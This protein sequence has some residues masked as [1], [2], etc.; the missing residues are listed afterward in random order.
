MGGLLVC[1]LRWA[2]RRSASGWCRRRI[3]HATLWGRCV[4]WGWVGG[5]RSVGAAWVVRRGATSNC[6][7]DG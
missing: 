1:A 3:A 7:S 6:H 2:G 5:V 4:R